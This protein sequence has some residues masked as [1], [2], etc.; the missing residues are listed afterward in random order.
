MTVSISRPRITQASGSA[1]T[2]ASWARPGG[3]TWMFR[4]GTATNSVMPPSTVTPSSSSFSQRFTRPTLQCRQ[5]PHPMQIST[6]TEAPTGTSVTR[7]PTATTSPVISWPTMNLRRRARIHLAVDALVA[8]ADPRDA[9]ADEDLPGAHGRDR[10][11]LED[12]AALGRILDDGEHGRPRASL[13]TAGARG[14]AP[15]HARST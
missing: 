9:H 11:V 15:P 2:A 14:A 4:A 13:R 10:H 7:S 8:A 5:M 12:D 3:R 1:N 6:A